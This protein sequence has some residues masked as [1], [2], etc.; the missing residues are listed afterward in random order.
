MNNPLLRIDDSYEKHVNNEKRLST[1]KELPHC[2]ANPDSIDAW[3]HNRMRNMILELIRL[4]PKSKW[5]TI[6]DGNHASDAYYLEQQGLDVTASSISTETLSIAHQLGY[7]QK[8]KAINAERI[9]EADNS[10]DFVYCK[11]AYHHFPRP[12]VALYEMLR[13]ANEGIV[14]IEPHESGFRIF[15]SVKMMIKLIFRGDNSFDFEPTG[16]YIFR[17][18][19]KE[20]KKM[21]TSL[22]LRLIAYKKFN[23]FYHPKLT[24]KS[25]K[26]ISIAKFIFLSGIFMQN[27]LCKIG[28]LDYGLVLLII[29][30]EEIEKDRLKH[31]KKNGFRISS[32]PINPYI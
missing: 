7:I 18:N 32:L 11:E 5:L 6:G 19:L 1:G 4:Y 27:I 24:S 12:P 2:Y 16:N 30:K 31:L 14:L 17:V 9:D 8:F 21:M 22:N 13:V 20:I 3:R 28:L 26:G 29:F 23:D 10:Y 15:S 25:I